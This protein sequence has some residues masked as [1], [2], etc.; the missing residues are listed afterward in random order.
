MISSSH[1]FKETSDEYLRHYPILK[2][3]AATIYSPNLPSTP[4][5]S[6]TAANAKWVSQADA[7]DEDES[8]IL[9]QWMNDHR[10]RETRCET[11]LK[12]P[13]S[14]LLQPCSHSPIRGSQRMFRSIL[15]ESVNYAFGSTWRPAAFTSFFHLLHPS[16]SVQ[17]SPRLP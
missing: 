2:I 15:S 16:F 6:K 17:R 9:I 4:P 11:A 1:T 12:F 13:Y 7:P 14:G 5:P 8:T 10:I 3:E